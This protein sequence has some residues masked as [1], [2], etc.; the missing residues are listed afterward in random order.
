MLLFAS[1]ITM[2]CMCTCVCTKRV[3]SCIKN[4]YMWASTMCHNVHGTCHV[5]RMCICVMITSSWRVGRG[6]PERPRI[7][8]VFFLGGVTY[9]EISA[10]R[11]LSQREDGM[12]NKFVCEHKQLCFL[13]VKR[14]GFFFGEYFSGVDR[15][16]LRICIEFAMVCEM[17][18]YKVCLEV[19]C[20]PRKV[21]T[22]EAASGGSVAHIV[23][24]GL[25][26]HIQCTWFPF[27]IK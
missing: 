16:I 23:I 10:L 14:F 6:T 12:K 17:C 9:A 1:S 25:W 24:F 22:F 3:Y 19:L 2:F 18:Q 13:H 5:T 21:S 4:W 15:E 27:W 7:V 26:P 20:L 8:L 11:Y